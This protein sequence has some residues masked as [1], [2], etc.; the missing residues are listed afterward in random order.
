MEHEHRSKKFFGIFNVVDI[1]IVVVAIALVIAA[2]FIIH[3]RNISA[4]GGTIQPIRYTIEGFQSLNDI[5]GIPEIGKEVYNSSTYDYLGKVV[6]LRVEPYT[7]RIFNPK[8]EK[9]EKVEIPN[10]V[11]LYLTIEGNGYHNERDVVVEGT[12]VK[13]G[14]E[15][16]VKGKGY[17]VK[18]YI[19]EIDI[20]EEEQKVE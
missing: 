16:N 9:F 13:V 2:Y 10:F 7:E 17:A 11:N 8:T 1:F 6:D 12:T 4:Q 20:G 19:V 15:L 18:S 3:S 5:E 14:S